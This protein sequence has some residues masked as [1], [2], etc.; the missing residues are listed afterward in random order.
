LNSLT[1]TLDSLGDPFKQFY[2]IAGQSEGLNSAALGINTLR[3]S[4]DYFANTD[5]SSF[6]EFFKKDAAKAIGAFM[7]SL[8]KSFEKS[9]VEDTITLLNRLARTLES[10]Y[11]TMTNL[12]KLSPIGIEGRVHFSGD[13][14]MKINAAN[15]EAREQAQ[16]KVIMIPAPVQAGPVRPSS[17]TTTNVTVN[18]TNHIDDTLQNAIFVNRF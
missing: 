3:D 6:M 1:R 7:T 10:L 13:E 18:E 17:N 12:D 2:T 14:L 8:S 9:E 4:L 16:Q 11:G 5:S 15:T